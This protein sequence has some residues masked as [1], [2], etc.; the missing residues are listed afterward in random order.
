MDKA[1]HESILKITL[2]ADDL[3]VT[4]LNLSSEVGTL[5][6]N[7]PSSF[8]QIPPELLQSECQSEPHIIVIIFSKMKKL[9]DWRTL[10]LMQYNPI[11]IVLQLTQ[12]HGSMPKGS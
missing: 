8:G 7:L 4:D 3:Y 5:E 2:D 1:L 6:R 10:N 9:K 11:C 12:N